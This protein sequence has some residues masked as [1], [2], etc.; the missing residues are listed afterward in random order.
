M[1]TVVPS[2]PLPDDEHARLEGALRDVE[3]PFACVDLDAFEANADDLVR[4]AA[5]MPIRVASKSVRCRAL[6]RAVLERPGFRGVLAYTLPE[7]LWL[8]EDGFDDLVVAYP[9]ADRGAL[10][11]LAAPEAE[12]ARSAIAI[13]VDAIEQLDFIDAVAGRDRPP[14]RVCID[15]DAGLW[16]AGGRVRIGARRSP[17]HTVDQAVA[18]AR[19]VVARPGLRLVGIMAY[20]AQIAGVADRPPGQRARGLAIRAM[21]RLSARELRARRAAAVEAVRAVA[22]LELVNGGGTGSVHGTAREAAVTEVAA[23]SGLYGPALFD[24]YRAFGVR[25]AALFA[26]PVVRRPG[27]GV[28]TVAGGGFPASG[29]AGADRLPVPCLPRGLRLDPQEGAGEVQTPLLGAAADRLA[30]GD[31][32]YF[33]H[34]KAGEVC[35]RFDE[36]HLVRGNQVVDAVPTYRGEG[37]AFG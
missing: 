23:G 34:A 24:H 31:R 29:A 20:E 4:R 15:L 35:E 18:L 32:V 17:V 27:R 1:T 10:R 22:P 16:L 7:A 6:L 33:R 13:M 2:R 9:T 12:A 26:V 19:E 5:G 30:I 37:R 25:P 14:L 28:V 8:A 3:A 36:L 11:A 21:Q